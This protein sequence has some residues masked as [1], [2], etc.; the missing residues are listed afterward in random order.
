MVAKC[1]FFSL[2]V[3]SCD[4]LSGTVGERYRGLA[5]QLAKCRPTAVAS[6]YTSS[7]GHSSCAVL[8]VVFYFCLCSNVFY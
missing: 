2:V 5:E 4:Y 8:T 7:H 1:S 6:V 3:V